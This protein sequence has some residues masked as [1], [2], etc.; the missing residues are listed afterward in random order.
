MADIKEVLW[1]FDSRLR[2]ALI[3]CTGVVSDAEREAVLDQAVA[4]L[5]SVATEFSTPGRSRTGILSPND[6]VVYHPHP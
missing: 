4:V 6:P 2:T 5:R 3:E 1:D